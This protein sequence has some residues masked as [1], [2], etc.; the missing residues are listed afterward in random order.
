MMTDNEKTLF[1]Q[2]K[3][4]FEYSISYSFYNGLDAPKVD[5]D[6]CTTME[7]T[8]AFYQTNPLLKETWVTHDEFANAWM[9]Y[10]KKANDAHSKGDRIVEATLAM[11]HAWLLYIM[12]NTEEDLPYWQHVVVGF[13]GAKILYELLYGSTMWDQINWGE[14][15]I[16]T[17]LEHKEVTIETNIETFYV[18]YQIDLLGRWHKIFLMKGKGDVREALVFIEQP[19]GD[20]KDLDYGYHPAGH[21]VTLSNVNRLVDESLDHLLFFTTIQD[22]RQK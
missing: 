11:S 5:P 14:L 15:K 1:F 9:Q 16:T 18:T 12:R 4:S 13:G 10:Y 20:L 22:P 2:K 19:K 17:D 8:K 6:T 3:Y 7:W 21:K